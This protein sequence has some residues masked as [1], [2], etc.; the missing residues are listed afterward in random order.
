MSEKQQN[1]SGCTL[2]MAVVIV[3][4]IALTSYVLSTGPAMRL[5]QMRYLSES[6]YQAIYYPLLV[7]TDN[8]VWA[9]DLLTRYCRWWVGK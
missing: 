5:V 9:D 3:I 7:I 2:A 6:G 8:V 4:A 1:R